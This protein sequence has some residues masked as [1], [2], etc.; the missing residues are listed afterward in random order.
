MANKMTEEQ[1]YEEAKKRVEAK[2]GFYA[3]LIVY[4]CVNILLII[5]W[6]FPAGGG[7]PWF[8]FPLGGWG[9]GILMHGLSVFVFE[10]KSD[11]AAIEK[12]ADKIRREQG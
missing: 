1:I 9:I 4:I 7:F 8:L 11:K 3:H 12:E 6:A 5:I 10:R 2:K